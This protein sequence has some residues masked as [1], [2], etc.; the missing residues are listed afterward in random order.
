MVNSNEVHPDKATDTTANIP[1][2]DPLT[3]APEEFQAIATDVVTNL[4]N[5]S[6]LPQASLNQGR[7]MRSQNAPQKRLGLKG[8]ATLAAMLLAALPTLTLGGFAYNLSANALEKK[9]TAASLARATGMAERTNAFMVDRYNNIQVIAQLPFLSTFSARNSLT[10][11]E[12]QAQLEFYRQTYGVYTSIAAFDLQGDVIAQSTDGKILDNHADRDYIQTVFKTQK[13][14]ISQPQISPTTGEVAIYF[15]API[16]DSETGEMIGVTRSRMPTSA[17]DPILST[18]NKNGE[19]PYIIDAHGSIIGALDSKQVGIPLTQGFGG[20]EAL[21][22]ARQAD[23]VSTVNQSSSSDQLASFYP[24]SSTPDL[25]DLEWSSMIS[26][27]KEI[28]FASQRQLLITLLL[29]TAA[30]TGIISLIAVYLAGQAT[31]PVIQAAKVVEKIGLGQFET[32]LSVPDEGDELVLLGQNINQMSSQLQSFLTTQESNTRLETMLAEITRLQNTEELAGPL[33]KALQE[34]QQQ[35]GGDRVIFARI[36]GPNGSSSILAEAVKPHLSNAR[37]QD[38]SALSSDQFTQFQEHQSCQAYRQ[39]AA[40]DFPTELKEELQ[41]L[42]V[43]S[44]LWAPVMVSNQCYGWLSLQTCDEAQDWTQDNITELTQIANRLG[45]SLNSVESFLQAQ[46]QAKQ[47]KQQND[48]LQ[49]E[50]LTLLSD[51]EG[52]SSGDLTVRAQITDGEI[53]IV[54]DFF[55][56]IVENLRDVVTQV[57][58]ASTQ[59]ND[60]VNSDGESIRQ[61]SQNAI[62]Q[63]TQINVTLASIEEMTSSLQ[64]VAKQATEAAQASQVAEATAKAGGEA[65]ES[66]VKSIS[67]VRQTVADTAKQVKRLG[68]SS[69]QISKVVELIN[70]IALK[71]NLLAVNAGIEA[72]RAGEE[73]RGFAVVAEEVGALAAQSALATKEIEQIIAAIQTET[74]NVV[75]AMETSTSQVVEGTRSVEEAK[76]SL[77]QVLEV[78][79]EVNSTFQLISNET[80]TQ[81]TVSEQVKQMMADVAQVSTDTSHASRDVSDSLQATAEITEQLQCS[82]NAFKVEEGAG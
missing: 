15:A 82:V 2:L 32:R 68:E 12:K 37:G 13:P 40:A 70:Q 21:W 20:L 24:F 62:G 56:A 4:S 64:N 8:K 26:T 33:E 31:K 22:Q 18:F 25:P 17:L 49:R 51:V 16:F 78:S 11:E 69:Q 48:N 35:M 57:K 7:A 50:L 76:Q 65:M 72:A 19:Q 1:E 44:C 66:T 3:P 80:I 9:L 23:S 6:K 34:I 45:L 38:L 30:V 54:A 58:Q 41:A 47:A 55:N 5:A 71:T 10:L 46:L 60:S 36:T 59:V 79:R 61:L 14:Y 28:I 39:L 43:R 75:E 74:S 81:A 63:A 27:D 52:A 73:G 29:G 67:Q 42:K 53:G 77:E